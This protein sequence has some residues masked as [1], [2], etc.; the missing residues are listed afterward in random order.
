[1]NPR[2]LSFWKW[3]LGSSKLRSSTKRRTSVDFVEIMPEAGLQQE[4][5]IEILV[6]GY[7]VRLAANPFR[8]ALL[9]LDHPAPS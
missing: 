2:T 1:V 3:K 5:P 4:A 8:S 7:R 6:E 9:R